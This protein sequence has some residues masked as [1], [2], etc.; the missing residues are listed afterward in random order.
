MNVKRKDYIMQTPQDK[1]TASVTTDKSAP[2]VT[3]C[4]SS[5]IN[6]SLLVLAILTALFFVLALV[7]GTN[8][9]A[10]PEIIG[11]LATPILFIGY[12]TALARKVARLRQGGAGFV[13]KPNQKLTNGTVNH[14]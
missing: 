10:F 1:N 7:A 3:L 9:M 5:W 12:L 4:K 2:I 6:I 13:S 14:A 8:K 11:R